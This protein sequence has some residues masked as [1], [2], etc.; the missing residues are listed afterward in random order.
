[1]F[2]GSVDVSKLR[3]EMAKARE[4][5]AASSTPALDPSELAGSL[6]GADDDESDYE[7]Q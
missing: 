5:G 4:V 2:T 7:Q 1:M 6:L 3:A